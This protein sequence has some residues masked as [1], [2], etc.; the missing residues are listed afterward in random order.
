MFCLHPSTKCAELPHSSVDCSVRSTAALT[1]SV[2]SHLGKIVFSPRQKIRLCPMHISWLILTTG[3]LKNF[4]GFNF[5]CFAF[6]FYLSLTNSNFVTFFLPSEDHT[7]TGA[8]SGT[9]GGGLFPSP[10][11]EY[12][13]PITA[14]TDVRQ[15]TKICS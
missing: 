8:A 15:R 6:R 12:W 14:N 2:C 4:F 13:T 5:D 11:N 7:Q 9:E 10:M 1:W 3:G